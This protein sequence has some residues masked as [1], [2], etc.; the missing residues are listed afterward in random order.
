M[1]QPEKNQAKKLTKCYS[2]VFKN[3]GEKLNSDAPALSSALRFDKTLQNSFV[4]AESPIE[5][6]HGLRRQ[7][8]SAALSKPNLLMPAYDRIFC[9]NEND[10][11][12]V[13]FPLNLT[14]ISFI[15]DKK[16]ENCQKGP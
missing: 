1:E 12:K 6:K 4:T 10:D 3:Y 11:A 15:T 13:I 16:L 2:E 14:F 8:S 7:S 5:Q 9:I